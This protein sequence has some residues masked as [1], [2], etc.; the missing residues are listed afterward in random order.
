MWHKK[1][2][3]IIR[4]YYPRYIDNVIRKKN[5]TDRTTRKFVVQM[6]FVLICLWTNILVN[7]SHLRTNF[8]KG[9]TP[10]IYCFCL[11]SNISFLATATKVKTVAT[12]VWYLKFCA[13]NFTSLTVYRIK[14]SLFLAEIWLKKSSL[15]ARKLANTITQKIRKIENCGFLLLICCAI[16]T[17]PIV[18]GNDPWSNGREKSI[19][20]FQ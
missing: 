10:W 13:W 14:I 19:K 17:N 9:D 8:V 4:N 7:F 2:K 16:V 20:L 6:Q 3:E 12:N 5:E 1:L 18:F 15:L 11:H